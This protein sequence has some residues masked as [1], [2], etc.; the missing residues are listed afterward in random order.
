MGL[1]CALHLASMEA[2]QEPPPA[3]RHVLLRKTL[4]GQAALGSSPGC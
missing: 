2:C 3:K 1:G 4:S